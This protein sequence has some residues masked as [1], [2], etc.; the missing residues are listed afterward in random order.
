MTTRRQVLATACA[1]TVGVNFPVTVHSQPSSSTP[2]IGF[3]SPGGAA[4]V[5]SF[6]ASLADFGYVE[7]RNIHI[8]IRAAN[9]QLDKLPDLAAEMVGLKLDMVAVVGAVTARA[10]QKATMSVPIVFAIVVDPVADHVVASMDRPGGNTSGVTSFDPQQARLQISLL[11]EAVPSLERIAILWDLGVSN[12]LTHANEE[13][14]RSLGMRPQSLGVR[15]ATPDIDGA[16][17]AMLSEHAGAVL[18][19]EEP[20]TVVHRKRIAELAQAQRLPS[21]FARDWVDAGGLMAYGT[22]VVEAVRHM[23]GFVDKILKGA[24]VGDLPIET[25]TRQELVLNVKT[26]REINLTF[27]PDLLAR[28]NRIVQ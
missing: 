2:R 10:V 26:A 3:I 22:S 19:L 14:A 18:V 8:D 16:F 25:V 7:G 6:R 12:L 27:S 24:N 13:A 23:A 4:V 17:A 28:A 20:V 1:V 5:E 11:K 9:G 15:G 21:M